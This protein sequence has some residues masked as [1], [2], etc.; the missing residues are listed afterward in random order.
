[1]MARKEKAMKKLGMNV[2]VLLLTISFLLFGSYPAS[3]ADPY[4][5]DVVNVNGYFGHCCSDLSFDPGVAAPLV[6]GS[7]DA[8]PTTTQNFIQLKD[9]S[10]ITLAFVDNVALSDGS[11]SGADLRIHTYDEPYPS[12]A[13]IEVSADG[14]TFY[15]LNPPPL[16]DS[17]RECAG[18]H[19]QY[20]NY[21][22]NEDGYID[23]DF[24]HLGLSLVRYVRITDLPGSI[25]GE[26]VYPDL[27]FDLD[28]IEALNPGP[29]VCV[30]PPEGLVSWWPADGNPFDIV[31]GYD[32][33]FIGIPAYTI[34]KV[35]QAFEFL[36]NNYFAVADNSM[37]NP[38]AFTVDAWIKTN[39]LPSP[40]SAHF[41]AAKSGSDGYHG[42]ELGTTVDGKVRFTVLAGGT[43]YGDALGSSVVADGEWHHIAGTY[44]GTDLR[45]YVDGNLETTVAYD[46]GVAYL[47]SSPI[48][49]GRRQYSSIPGYFNGLIDEVEIFDHALIDAEIRGIFY[50]GSVGKCRTCAIPPLDNSMVSWWP[51]DGNMDD[52]VDGNI[53]TPQGGV[54]F[55]AGKVGQAFKFNGSAGALR[56]GDV[57]DDIFAG[58]NK[59]F[60]IDLWT[61]VEALPN[62]V[63]GKTVRTDL[64][65]KLGDS[66]VGPEDQRQ[67]ALIL[68]PTGRL[69][70]AFYGALNGSSLRLVRTDEALT[71]ETWHHISIVYD[72]SI[73]TNDGLD[74]VN[75]YINGVPQSTTLAYSTGALGDIPNGS[76]NLSLGAAVASNLDAGYLLNGK[77]D[78]VEILNRALTAEEIR[79]IVN[80]GNAGK[81]RVGKVEACKFYD[82]D[83]DGSKIGSEPFL[84]GWPITISPLDSA[85]PPKETQPTDINGCV[86]WTN[87]APGQYTISEGTPTQDNWVHTNASSVNVDVFIGKGTGIDFGNVC[88]G[89]GGARSKGYWS[90]KNGQALIADADLEALSAL[91]LMNE[92]GTGFDPADNPSLS[93]WLREANATNMAYMLS[94]QLAAM[95]LNVLHGFV[96]GSSFVLAGPNPAGCSVPVNGA[97]FLSVNDLIEDADA[98]LGV[99]GYTPAGDPERICQEFKKN[100]L[101][102]ANNNLNFVQPN[103][104]EATFP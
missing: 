2:S 57:L 73:D 100:A 80:A 38:S 23:L 87:L 71:T 34:G 26:Y 55:D 97:G 10:S 37:L 21:D 46:G 44:D 14:I 3:A 18:D 86:T 39:F 90:N 8:S 6:L 58:A 1:M 19:S 9:G 28:A 60:T 75:I 69:D 74:R 99:D 36:G 95:K 72:G 29:R 84:I 27:G 64:F 42:Y 11:T 35:D 22:D 89:P 103:P 33:N 45:I 66:V 52:I 13:I 94:A 4:A 24:D 48:Y 68:R 49:I 93:T 81:C 32:G 50:A 5:D 79:A 12:A 82:F 40:Y 16:N 101:D 51:G 92:N 59:K 67:F 65:G 98:E 96:S 53:G 85:V 17:G 15:T 78:E 76:A 83:T 43:P 54:T 25:D 61:K 102:A 63:P 70:F 62:G 31:R 20:C 77:I 88:L 7:P 30:K 104:C 91:N 56:F 47:A 41:I